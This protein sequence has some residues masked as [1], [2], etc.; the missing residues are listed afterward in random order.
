MLLSRSFALDS[1]R[2]NSSGWGKFPMISSWDRRPL[3]E[4]R[5]G[6]KSAHIVG[7]QILPDR[8]IIARGDEYSTN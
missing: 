3:L 5:A 6:N 8:Q 7:R 2:A 4:R 1:S